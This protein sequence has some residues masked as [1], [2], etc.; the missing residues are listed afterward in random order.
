MKA[1]QKI[2]IASSL[3]AF[4]SIATA[5][6]QSPFSANVALTTDYVFR[7]ISQSAEDPAIQG[8]FDFNHA[9]G[10][11]AGVWGSNVEFAETDTA[12]VGRGAQMEL[13]VYGGYGWQAAGIDWDAG[14]IRYIYPGASGSR[15]YDFN[16]IY[17]S[18]GKSFGTVKGTVGLNYS[19]DYFAGSGNATYLYLDVEVPLPQDFALAL[20]AGKQEI[21]NNAAFG[22]PDYTDY[23]VGISKEFGGFGF[24]LDFIDTD[25][26]KSEC[27]SNNCDSRVVFTVSKSM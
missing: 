25:L 17:G 21:D 22:T 8:G 13:D 15:N 7:G 3:S 10:F 2:I 16:E 9:S 4:T 23:K 12:T 5:A 20:H 6:E 1:V 11:Y 19:D 14:V 26:S 24:A 18:V 27:G